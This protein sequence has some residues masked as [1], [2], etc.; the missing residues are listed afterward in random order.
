[1]TQTILEKHPYSA[2][3]TVLPMDEHNRTL[4]GNVHPGDWRNPVPEGRYNLVVIGGGTAGLV[5][6]GGAAALGAKVA[7]VEKHLLGGD[8]LNYGCVPSKAI[9]RAARAAHEA[10]HAN[11]FGVRVP[12]EAQVDFPAV[13][14]RM[15]ELR[16]RISVHDAASNL[17]AQGVD[18][19]LGEAAFTGPDTVEASGR[20]LRFKKA[21]IATGARPVVPPIPG[22]KEAGFQTNETIFSLTQLPPRL[23]VVGGGP[24]GCE[25]AQTFRRF[26]SQVT[27]LDFAPH[28]L[29]REAYETAALLAAIFEREGIKVKTRRKLSRVELKGDEKILHLEHDGQAETLAV[30]EILV[31]VGRAPNVEGLQLEK[32]GVNYDKT[33][34]AVNDKLQTS[35][36][37]IYAAGDVCM[38]YKFT[39][40]ADAAA[41][42]VIQNALFLP[43]AK[44]S[45]AVI[46]WCT[47]T[48]P[49]IAH[50]GLTEAEAKERGIPLK[51]LAKSLCEVDR[52]ILDG[53]EEG[54]CKLY[55]DQKSGR[56]LGGTIVARHAGEMIGELV[57]ALQKKLSPAHLAAVIHPYPTQAEAIRKAAS[58][59]YRGLM[60]GWVKRGLSRY[61]A[62]TR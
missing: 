3:V 30:D 17:Q 4:V 9:I 25:M 45:T 51:V 39:H 16:A 14:A 32:A 26:G 33:G 20:L 56:L 19:Y 1:M 22:L 40:A 18:V 35:N 8:C 12:G 13:M 34:V 23:A 15:R 10:R 62:W 42:V 24:I 49:E 46:P 2:P 36:P 37:N 44:I 53:E 5:T 61:F 55:C 52:A 43:T 7:L 41:R 29:P 27:I 31:G 38:A 60:P 21:V 59:Q 11:P 48:D 58:E 6:A 28:I 54:F 47:Y 57:L 50:V